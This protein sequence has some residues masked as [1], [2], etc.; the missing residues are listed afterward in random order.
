MGEFVV[1][2]LLYVAAATA[3]YAWKEYNKPGSVV[4]VNSS[5]GVDYGRSGRKCVACGYKGQ[6]VT[7]IGNYGAPQ[8]IILIGFLFMIIPGLIFMCL[9]WGKYKCPSCGAIGKN[10]PIRDSQV[11]DIVPADNMHDTKACP[12][13]AET[14][15]QAAIV[16]RYC[17]RELAPIDQGPG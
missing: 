13:C 17:N 10:Q 1:M 6:M 2:I 12:F 9:Y 14:I 11:I 16:C 5:G 15:K 8:F 3:Y 7:W 4:P